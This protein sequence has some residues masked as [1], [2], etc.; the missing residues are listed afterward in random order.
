MR[1]D[2]QKG[3]K[4]QKGRMGRMGRMGRISR[5]FTFGPI[6]PF[7]PFCKTATAA[8]LYFL[9]LS[10][11]VCAATAPVFADPPDQWVHDKYA[12]GD[13]I[14]VRGS[15]PADILVSA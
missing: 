2:G 7:C 5:I 6:S 1:N 12:K 10:V 14:L 3:L 9:L 13:F 4:G 8:L 11:F 15:E